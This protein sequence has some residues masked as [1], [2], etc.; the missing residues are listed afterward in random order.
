M[1]PV[2]ATS[3]SRH[4]CVFISRGYVNARS[5]SSGLNPTTYLTSNR[6]SLRLMR[7]MT[8]RLRSKTRFISLT[9]WWR[10]FFPLDGPI[11]E[12]ADL[13]DGCK[14]RSFVFFRL[15]FFSR[16]RHALFLTEAI[17]VST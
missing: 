1:R 15:V 5:T 4:W 7:K 13:V 14:R 3:V 8:T 2:L 9:S 11:Q 12:P 6:F 17:V 16:S 10:I